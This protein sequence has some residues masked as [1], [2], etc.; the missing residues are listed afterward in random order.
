MTNNNNGAN[1]YL[2]CVP[3]VPLMQMQ[4]KEQNSALWQ[5]YEQRVAEFNAFDPEIVFVFGGD[6]YHGVH[7]KLMPT[8]IIGQIA[9]AIDDCGGT[10]GKLDIPLEISQ[11]CVNFLMAE[12]F[13]IATSY[14]M[15]IDHGFSNVLAAFMGDLSS[16]PVI[17]IHINSMSSPRPTMKRCRELGEAIGKFAKT[18]NKR[19]AILG[20][21]G[22][23]HQTNFIFPEYGDAEQNTRDF[24]VHGGTQGEIS[25][26]AWKNGIDVGM[27]N[28]SADLISG[29]FV[30]PWINK[31]W[32]ERF[33]DVFGGNNLSAFDDWTDQEI[34][35]AAGYGG[36]EVRMWV[37][38]AA[39][40]QAAGGGPIVVDF[41]S[42]N[43][44]LAIGAGIA[45]SVV[46]QVA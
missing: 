18:L 14:A 40:S 30:A 3:H 20:S 39:A 15:V 12:S 5:A 17:P 41:Y 28:L 26:D 34:L 43:T 8:F 35:E 4:P 22:L 11:A 33:L 9:E 38:A 19:V 29:K 32:D 16:R 6:H 7:L 45:H 46:E 44:T 13:D 23:S 25:L 27:Q 2:A 42:E 37:A 10:P 36:G 1:I 31:E 21:G 24:I